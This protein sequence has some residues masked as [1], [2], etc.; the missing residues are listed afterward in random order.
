MFAHETEMSTQRLIKHGAPQGAIEQS[1]AQ[2]VTLRAKQ[3]E[4]RTPAQRTAVAD[5][6]LAKKRSAHRKCVEQAGG[7]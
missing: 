7:A 5:A 3:A 6:T 4:E 1:K 2:A